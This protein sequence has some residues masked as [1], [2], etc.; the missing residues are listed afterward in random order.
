MPFLTRMGCPWASI[1]KCP[2]P[3]KIPE[4]G[5]VHCIILRVVGESEDKHGDEVVKKRFV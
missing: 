3:N 2:L 1:R 5:S 4:N